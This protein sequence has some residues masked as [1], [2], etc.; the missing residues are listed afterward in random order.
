MRKF[1][2]AHCRYRTQ[3]PLYSGDNAEFSVAVTY[4]LNLKSDKVGYVTIHAAEDRRRCLPVTSDCTR[5]L[6]TLI[7]IYYTTPQVHVLI[8]V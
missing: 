8:I 4:R 1:M 3:Y 7:N 2:T 6:R 5:N